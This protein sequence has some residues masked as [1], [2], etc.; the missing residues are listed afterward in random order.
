MFAVA[1]RNV[2]AQFA[3]ERERALQELTGAVRAALLETDRHIEAAGFDP[4]RTIEEWEHLAHLVEMPFET[5]RSGEFTLGDVRAVALAWIDRQRMKA[6]FATD[7][8][9][10]ARRTDASASSLHSD[11]DT[12]ETRRRR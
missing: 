8:R 1:V 2:G 3:V 10:H 5:I 7:A 9:S 6:T 11:S 4:P 12:D